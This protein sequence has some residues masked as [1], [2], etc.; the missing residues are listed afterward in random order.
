MFGGLTGAAVS[1]IC[2]CH[3]TPKYGDAVLDWRTM[4]NRTRLVRPPPT[5]PAA[6]E[7]APR[8]AYNH[9]VSEPAPCRSVPVPVPVPV[10]IV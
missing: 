3:D 10:E 7:I 9:A 6:L 4:A 1:Q 8:R 2:A 5:R